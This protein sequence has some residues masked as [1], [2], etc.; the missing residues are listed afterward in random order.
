MCFS[1][2]IRNQKIPIIAKN[3]SCIHRCK[4]NGGCSVRIKSNV[5]ISGA[6]LGSCFPPLFGGECSGIPKDCKPCIDVCTG[7]SD[8]ELVVHLDEDGNII[9]CLYSYFN[10]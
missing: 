10:P 4:K 1:E 2:N 5:M 6:V 8:Q 3:A 9:L 7:Y